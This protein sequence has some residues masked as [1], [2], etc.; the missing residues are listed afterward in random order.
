MTTQVQAFGPPPVTSATKWGR[1]A[2]IAVLIPIA[3]F[4]LLP[5]IYNLVATPYRLDKAV[6]YADSYNPGLHEVVAH[7]YVTL[8]AFDALD[9][10]KVSLA[11]VRATDATV[12]AELEKL[13]AQISTDLQS[14]LNSANGNVGAM[15]ASLD[16]LTADLNGL[17]APVNGATGALTDA[18]ASLQRILDEARATAAQVHQA[19]QSAQG[20]ASNVSGK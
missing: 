17:H 6:V 7:E 16:R 5:R 4:Y 18:R 20:S 3:V 12:A 13:V 2:V 19:S 14:T 10:I 1:A 11:D 15:L 9:Q 8:A